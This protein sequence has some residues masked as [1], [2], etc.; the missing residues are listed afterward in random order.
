MSFN[1]FDW[2]IGNPYNK[3]AD[4]KYNSALKALKAARLKG[5]RVAEK[6]ALSNMKQASHAMQNTANQII[7]KVEKIDRGV[8][9]G[10][11]AIKKGSMIG[12]GLLALV[13]LVKVIKK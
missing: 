2:I 7:A 1:I 4:K 13:V 3:Q 12:A 5:D 9:V 8:S 11:S 10:Y 6:A